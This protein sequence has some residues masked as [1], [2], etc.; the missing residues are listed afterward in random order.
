MQQE[1]KRCS[2]IGTAAG[3][4]SFCQRLFT[5]EEVSIASQRAFCS[6]ANGFD[7]NFDCAILAFQYIGFLEIKGKNVV[8][9]VIYDRDHP[10][11][12]VRIICHKCYEKLV[13]DNMLNI[14]KIS[15]DESANQFYISKSAFSLSAAVFRNMLISFNAMRPKAGKFVIPDDYDSIFEYSIEEKRKKISLEELQQ[16]LELQSAIGDKGELFVMDYEKKRIGIQKQN[17]RRISII[18]VAAGYDIASYES[19][20][21]NCF[22]RFIEVKTFCGEKKFHWSKNEIEVARLRRNKY[23]IYLVDF[24][25][26]EQTNYTPEI[27]QDPY[28]KIV[29]EQTWLMNPESWMVKPYLNTDIG[30]RQSSSMA[31]EEQNGYTS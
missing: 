20:D 29:E 26:I 6:Y 27:I 23:F 13:E 25:K 14:N 15:F 16:K 7:L 22:D 30:L 12:I 31:A 9:N 8:S 3:I 24:R 21:S 11:K 19:K 28:S 4:L 5:G 10:D 1:L 17:P 18:D 2:N